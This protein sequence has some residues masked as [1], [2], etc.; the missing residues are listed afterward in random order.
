MAALAYGVKWPACNHRCPKCYSGV[1]ERLLCASLSSGSGLKPLV[2]LCTAGSLR[3]S[4]DPVKLE[5]AFSR[6]L[7]FGTG[8]IRGLMGIGPNRMNI[9]T[10][11]KSAQGLSSF[12]IAG[13]ERSSGHLGVAPMVAIAYDTRLHSR[14]FARETARVLAANGIRVLLFSQPQPT[15]VLSFATRAL[16]CDC[17]V[18]I[19]ASHNPREYN[20]FKVYGPTGDQA[21]DALAVSIQSEIEKVDTFTGVADADFDVLLESGMISPVPRERS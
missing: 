20:G 9:L 4:I 2:E 10:V 7:N 12:L 1:L 17:G 11:G 5:D 13:V 15:P 6:N 8:G 14:D 18:C 3:R 19:T 16:R 21:T